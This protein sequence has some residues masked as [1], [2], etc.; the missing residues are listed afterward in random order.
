MGEAP[1]L[2]AEV[3]RAEN[4]LGSDAVNTFLH[5]WQE[6]GELRFRQAAER[7]LE[8]LAAQLTDPD[9]GAAADAVRAYRR[10][11]GDTRYD[12]AVLETVAGLDPFDITEV[13]LDTEYKRPA[14][15]AS[16]VG[17]RSDAPRWLEDGRE[18]SPQSDY[19][20][21]GRGD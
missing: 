9:A 8:P 17:K 3:D 20:G 15:R 11:T 14:R 1:D 5:L 21:G 4:L 19:A 6:R 13:A 10:W 2:Q 12:R 18:R 7:L 16:G